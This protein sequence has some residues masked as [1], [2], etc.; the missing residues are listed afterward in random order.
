[1]CKLLNVFKNMLR[2]CIN[3]SQGSH[4]GQRHWDLLEL[5]LE[6]VVSHP[7]ICD[8]NCLLQ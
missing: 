3:M 6:A 5:E 2:A 4:R 7:D 1:M 8:R